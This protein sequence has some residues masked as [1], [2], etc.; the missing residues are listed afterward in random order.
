M[1]SKV[2]VKNSQIIGE[3]GL[4]ANQSFHKGDYICILPIDY[5]KI[6]DN[7]YTLQEDNKGPINFR[8][9]IKV[10]LIVPKS[11]INISVYDTFIN[12]LKQCSKV[13]RSSICIELVGVSNHDKIENNFLGHMI[14]DYTDMSL[15]DKQKYNKISTFHENVDVSSELELFEGNRLGLKVFAKRYIHKDE[16][17][18]FNYGVDYWKNY[19]GQ[20]KF[21][22]S[23]LN[24]RLINLY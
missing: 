8:Y 9:G 21:E 13:T 17:L 15:L 22:V 3:R 2:Y 5:L 1:N 11:D 4:F 6:G 18:F 16:E 20:G 12:F 7:W 24:I 10:D 19:S 14:N 23:Q